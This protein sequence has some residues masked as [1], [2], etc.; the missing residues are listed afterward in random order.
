[1]GAH[2]KAQGRPPGP[3]P[4]GKGGPLPKKFLLADCQQASPFE[5]SDR[6]SPSKCGTSN[7]VTLR[8]M[9]AVIAI[10]LKQSRRHEV[11]GMDHNDAI[12][13]MG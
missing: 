1:M 2:C 13:E 9:V 10:F 4:G 11:T 6:F 7:T 12:G 8:G 5:F 3:A